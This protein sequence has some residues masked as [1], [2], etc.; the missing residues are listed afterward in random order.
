MERKHYFVIMPV[1]IFVSVWA[2]RIEIESSSIW[3]YG[4]DNHLVAGFPNASTIRVELLE[5]TITTTILDRKWD[6]RTKQSDVHLR[7]T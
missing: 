2:H 5:D 1:A 4:K 6:T 7:I 3:F